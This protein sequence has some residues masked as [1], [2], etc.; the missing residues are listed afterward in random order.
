MLQL[1]FALCF[2]ISAWFGWRRNPLYSKR[3]TL[4]SIGVG[5]LAIAGAVLLI[6]AAVQLTIHRSPAVAFTTLAVVIVIVTLGLIFVIQ[7]LTVPQGGKPASLPHATRLV[8]TNRAK[9]RK[10]A[11]AFGI[12]IAILVI[13]GLLIPGD[14]RYMF[15]TFAGFMAFFAATLLPVLYWTNRGF[16]QSLTAIELNPWVHWQYTPEQW[17]AWSNIQADR[18]KA[19]PPTFILR[20]S[21]HRFV[22]VFGGIAAGV[23]IICPGEWLWKTIYIVAVCSLI[24]GVVIYSGRG[25]APHA[26]KL[27]AKLLRAAPEAYLGRDGLFC[28]GVFLPWINISTYLVSAAIDERQPR[29]ALFNFELSVP[30]PYGPTQVVH[31]HQAVLIPDGKESDLARLQQDL[32]TRCPTAQIILA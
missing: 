9:V 17:T 31:I 7:T 21:W 25:G 4:I 22:W 30:N 11:K 15:L 12:G 26:E 24:A 19:M 3:A 6:A 10:W 8:T 18:L 20:K 1:V 2:L 27:R 28:D 32:S 13:P 14:I 23:Y 29:S 16:D 5:L